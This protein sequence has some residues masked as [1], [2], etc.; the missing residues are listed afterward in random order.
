MTAAG[1]RS[2]V[3]NYRTKGGIDRRLTIGAHPAWSLSAA[4]SEA[5]RLK[6]QVD[7]GGDPLADL[8]A[9]R[10]A[11]TV[12]D[13]CNRFAAEHLPGKR[14]STRAGYGGIITRYIIPEIGNR[15][16]IRHCL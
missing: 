15:T 14:P 6:R 8:K 16:V 11:P 9:H 10:E 7:G 2:F 12:A 5:H 13:L 1:A 3:F 4:R